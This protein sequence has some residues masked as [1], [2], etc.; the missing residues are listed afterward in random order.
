MK[1]VFVDSGYWIAIL[2]KHDK[3]HSRAV[4]VSE[5]A[6]EDRYV[7]TDFVL[8]EILNHLA[9]KGNNLREAA[10]RTVRVIR[11]APNSIVVPCTR[12]LFDQAVNRYEQRSD[13]K[14]WGLT[15][16]ASFVIMEQEKIS[17]ALAYDK[18]FQQAGFRAL[19]RED[20]N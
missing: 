11:D 5:N 8:L 14:E 3:L 9:N 6:R 12:I 19:L 1:K 20:T 4:E 16:C 17:D 10:V 13:D 2:N 15:D 18:H 7:T